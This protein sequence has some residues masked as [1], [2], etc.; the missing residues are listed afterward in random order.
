MR[1]LDELVLTK[2]PKQKFYWD[3]LFLNFILFLTISCVVFYVG[4]LHGR[5]SVKQEAVEK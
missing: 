3:F 4:Y 5:D 2:R 1:A